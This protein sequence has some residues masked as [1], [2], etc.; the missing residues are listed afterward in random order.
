MPSTPLPSHSSPTSL[1]CSE[2]PRVLYA[3]PL[4]L[5]IKNLD[6]NC[7]I[8]I[9]FWWINVLSV[10]DFCMKIVL[11]VSPIL[12]LTC[13]FFSEVS[14][15]SLLFVHSLL[16]TNIYIGWVLRVVSNSTTPAPRRGGGVV[17]MYI[18]YRQFPEGFKDCINTFFRDC[19]LAIS[20]VIFLPCGRHFC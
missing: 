8:V 3:L 15:I 18:F 13:C 9:T 6:V 12:V 14:C 10:K 2:S 4:A 5:S 16:T 11:S 1:W 20:F 7:Y 19:L 17:F